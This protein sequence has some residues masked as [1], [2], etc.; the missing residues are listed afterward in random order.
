MNPQK[1][2]VRIGDVIP[3]VITEGTGTI[4]ERARHPKEFSAAEDSAEKLKVDAYWYL[5]YQVHPPVSR[6]L[7]PFNDIDEQQIASF[8]GALPPPPLFS[9]FALLNGFLAGL[10][11]SEFRSRTRTDE[12]DELDEEAALKSLL[13]EKERYMDCVQLKI[14]CHYCNSRFVFNVDSGNGLR[15]PTENCCGLVDIRDRSREQAD[16]ARLQNQLTQVIRFY[17]SQYYEGWMVCDD[18]SC[19]IRTRDYPPFDASQQL[20]AQ[21]DSL[22]CPNPKCEGSLVEE[23]RSLPP[24]LS[25]VVA[26]LLCLPDARS[27]L[28]VLGSNSVHAALVLPHP[29]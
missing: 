18:G 12:A 6:L 25:F 5:K 23:V 28:A 10:N 11:T 20:S 22:P 27:V 13:D 21:S 29:V 1:E 8:L 9:S 2:V 7:E 17:L 16:I 19:R 15:C 26:P 14:T 3:Y 4:V 24:S